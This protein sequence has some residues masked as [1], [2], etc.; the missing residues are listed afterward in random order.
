MTIDPQ[1]P[2]E[3]YL[4]ER[5]ATNYRLIKQ[6]QLCADNFDPCYLFGPQPALIIGLQFI[7]DPLLPDQEALRVEVKRVV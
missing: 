5:T 2:T 7:P 1:T 3:V 4:I 6:V